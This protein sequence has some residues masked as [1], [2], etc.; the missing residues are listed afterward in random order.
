MTRSN[1]LP[2]AF[3]EL[4][5]IGNR[6]VFPTCLIKAI[7]QYFDKKEEIKEAQTWIIS[8]LEAQHKSESQVLIFFFSNV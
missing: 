4:E 2:K 1:E 8:R 7:Y 5:T 3:G 6:Q